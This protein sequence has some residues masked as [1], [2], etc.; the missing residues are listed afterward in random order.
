MSGKKSPQGGLT[1]RGFLKT[2]GAVG[3][4]GLAGAVGMTTAEGWLAPAEATEVSEE[5]VA[6]TYHQTHCRG[7]CTLKCTVRDGRLCLIEPNEAAEAGFRKLCVKGLSEIQHVYSTERVQTP[8][9]RVGERGSG[10][11]I[12]I[13][14]EEAM[15]IFAEN[16]K[17]I[18]AEHGKDAVIAWTPGENSQEVAELRNMLS[19][20]AG[21]WNGIDIGY[22]NGLYPLYGGS[23]SAANGVTMGGNEITD[24]VNTKTLLVVGSNFVESGL[25][26]C[27]SFFDAQDAGM[28]SVMFDPIFTPSAGKCDEWVPME[29]GTDPALFLGLISCVLDGGWIDE[30][31]IRQHTT[32]P[33]LVSMADGSLYRKGEGDTYGV[34][35]EDGALHAFD[36]AGLTASLEGEI[37]IDGVKYQTAFSQLKANAVKYDAAWASE[38]TGIPA[39]KIAEVAKRYATNGPA[40]IDVGYG[41]GDRFQNADIAGH[42]AGILA[43]ITGNFGLPGTGVGTIFNGGYDIG[44]LLGSWPLPAD[45]KTKKLGFPTWDLPYRENNIKAFITWGD[46]QQRFPAL[47]TAMEWLKTLDFI[48]AADVYHISCMDYAD[49]V[50]PIASRFE[51]DE[52]IGGVRTAR[53]HVAMRQKVLDPLFE[54][55]TD[56]AAQYEI[57]KALGLEDVLPKTAEERAEYQLANTKSAR[58]KGITLDDLKKNNGVVSYNDFGEEKHTF[59]DFNFGSS[60]GRLEVYYEKMLEFGQALPVWE[61]PHQVYEEGGKY[62]LR[63]LQVKTRYHIHDQ[64]CDAEW[65]RQFYETNLEMNPADMEARGLETGDEVEIFND[66]GSFGCKALA[67]ESVRPGTVKIYQGEWTKYM[68]FGNLQNVTN[69]A[70]T[71]RGKA[72]ANGPVILSNDV[73]VEV[74][75]A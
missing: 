20:T 33:F 63:F 22:A 69:P 57:A 65:I 68:S 3:A 12:S 2:T 31:F 21:N 18:W 74:K 15:E 66:W 4:L 28:Y 59:S 45:M 1:R 67:N 13:T 37:E 47:D 5:R 29:S 52:E 58:I 56:F 64:F 7:N 48:V 54:S 51:C 34:I 23:G 42:A 49:L 73:L 38:V 50:L 17:R 8:M 70:V 36:E 75:K 32:F 43:A 14:W 30:D 16:I 24:L 53:K 26:H 55:K 62:P 39:D 71:E 19:C 72:L 27:S 60:T 6:Y 40:V 44:N 46:L 10:E 25:P 41:G 11:F 61:P 9:K 35:G